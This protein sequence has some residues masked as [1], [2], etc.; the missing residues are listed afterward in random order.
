MDQTDNKII[1]ILARE[2]RITMRQLGQRVAMSGTAVAERVRRL[3]EAGVIRGYHAV[4][5]RSRCGDAVHAYIV[6]Q[7]LPQQGLNKDTIDRY[8][9]A[10]PEI[11]NACWLLTG[12]MDLILEIY[13]S[14]V[15]TLGEIQKDLCRHLH[16]TTYVAMP[17][18]LKEN[19]VL[20]QD[21][22][23]ANAE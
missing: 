21:G 20:L 8:I 11:V 5:E 7:L 10:R 9:A 13:C 1:A 14:R 23:Q 16:T 17:R 2:G 6:A 15:E 4:L 3:E 22:G 18:S 19:G 12:G